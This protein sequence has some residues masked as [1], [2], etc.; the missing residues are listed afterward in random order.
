MEIIK[1]ILLDFWSTV[2]EMS[3]YLLFGF[4]VAGMLSVLISQKLVERHLGGVGLWQL[5]KASVFGV[6]LPLC[7]CGVIPVSMSLY[8]HGASKGAVVSFLLSTPQT[9]V[10]SIFVTLSLLGPLF[11]IFRP[12]AAFATGVIGGGAVNLLE[13]NSKPENTS[14]QSCNESCCAEGKKNKIGRGIKYGF[15]TL[16]RDIGKAMLVGLA[17]AA[18]IS[19]LVPDGYFAEKLGTG[20]FA[21]V[22]M[23]F[24]GIPVYVCATAS[25]PVAAALMLKGLTPGAAIVFLMT[26]PATNAASFVTILKT[27]GF[28][29]AIT[30]IL[31]VAVCALISGL[32]LDAIAAGIDFEVISKPAWMMPQLVKNI[33][34]VVLILLLVSGIMTRHKE[35]PAADTK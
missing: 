6:P 15:V 26:G 30:Y 18:A 4:F 16:P 32:I 35:K 31:S 25:V 12:L 33:C 10:D 1:K 3:P 28:K 17:I 8:R 27:L 19:A 34:A 9:G 11:A 21:M 2:G 7:S 29:T 13:R 5:V 20:I 14:Q 23:M 22:V 24:L